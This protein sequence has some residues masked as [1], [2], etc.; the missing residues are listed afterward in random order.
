[1]LLLTRILAL[2]SSFL[3]LNSTAET[4]S[5]IGSV[6]STTCDVKLEV[7]GSA[8]NV[9]N[10]GS[11]GLNAPPDPSNL[12]HFSLKPDLTQAGCAGLTSQNTVTISWMGNFNVDSFGFKGLLG[13]QS[14]NA[15]DA[16][17]YWTYERE[18]WPAQFV[19]RDTPFITIPGDDFL[20]MGAQFNVLLIPGRLAGTFQSA[21][22]YVMSY[23]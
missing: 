19:T 22:A 10:L 9:V 6:N 8:T 23:N 18:P 11:V 13:A 15:T 16:A 2:C 12:V 1:M 20:K 17:I 3:A 14:G 7:G 4:L 21:A 5:F